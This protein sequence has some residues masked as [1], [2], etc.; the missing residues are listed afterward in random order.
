VFAKWLDAQP[1]LLVLD[2]PTRGVD[3]SARAEMHGVI[4]SIAGAGRAVL[5]ASTDLVELSGLADRVL[6][7]QHGRL[8]REL[9]RDGLSERTLSVAMN[10]GFANSDDGKR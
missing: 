10:V 9:A 2:D 1:A 5:L 3:V 6:I 7:F 8:V 4:A